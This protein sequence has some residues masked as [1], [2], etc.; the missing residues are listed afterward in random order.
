MAK[1]GK[2]LIIACCLLSM[3]T[4]CGNSS[5]GI[6]IQNPWARPGDTGG[7]SAVYFEIHNGGGSDQLV[8]ATCSM[9]KKTE[10]HRSIVDSEGKARMEHQP[11]V[12]IPGAEVITFMP[13]GLHVM[14]INLHQPLNAGDTFEMTL[15]FEI[16][17][18]VKINVSVQNP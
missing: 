15:N 8:S 18:K 14:L 11:N 17:G 6:D 13:G 4:A 10:L 3:L 16:Y 1:T 2:T 5:R 9:A 7:N 12:Q